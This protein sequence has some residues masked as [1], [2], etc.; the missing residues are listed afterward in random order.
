MAAPSHALHFTSLLTQR[1]DEHGG[2]LGK[3]TAHR[4]VWREHQNADS[5]L[6]RHDVAR[7]DIGATTNPDIGGITVEVFGSYLCTN[8]LTSRSR[9]ESA[10]R[11]PCP[12][13]A[14]KA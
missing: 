14:A 4:R 7:F 12:E 3:R 1:I 11:W 8:E 2:V 6:F 10:L 13:V 5:T 9:S